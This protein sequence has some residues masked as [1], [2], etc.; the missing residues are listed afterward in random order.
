M[1]EYYN[2]WERT[3]KILVNDDEI[4]LRLITDFGRQ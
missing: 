2:G 4:N 3:I 1:L